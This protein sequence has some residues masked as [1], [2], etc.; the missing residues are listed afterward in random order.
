MSRP[1]MHYDDPIKALEAAKRRERQR[2][3][4]SDPEVRERRRQYMKKYQQKHR[5]ENSE[6]VKRSRLRKV[7]K[8]NDNGKDNDAD[9]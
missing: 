4:F 6:A 3:Y 8:E 9:R 7:L 2:R 5:K 1:I